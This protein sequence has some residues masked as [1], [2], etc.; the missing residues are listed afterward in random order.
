[1]RSAFSLILSKMQSNTHLGSE[2]DV[3]INL[4]PLYKVLGVERDV[5]DDKLARK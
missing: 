5:F 4:T 3:V 1:M 2:T